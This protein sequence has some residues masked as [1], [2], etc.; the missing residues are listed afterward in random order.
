[1]HPGGSLHYRAK[2]FAIREDYLSAP[3]FGVSFQDGNWA[4]VLDPSTWRL[5]AAR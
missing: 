5:F 3:L 1:L 4:A 2:R